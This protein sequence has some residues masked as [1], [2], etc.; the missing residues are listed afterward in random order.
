MSK[1]TKHFTKD[2]A[3]VPNLQKFSSTVQTGGTELS[4]L[5]G[6]APIPTMQ[7]IETAPE[8]KGAPV[9]AMQPVPQPA[10]T[11][12]QNQGSQGNQVGNTDKK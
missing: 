12:Q 6:G 9:P 4:N 2:G 8:R 3:P 10:Q 5:K 1:V 7:K 11:G